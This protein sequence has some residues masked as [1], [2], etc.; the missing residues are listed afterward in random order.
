MIFPNAATG[1]M[2][3]QGDASKQLI[4]LEKMLAA[5]ETDYPTHESI[6]RPDA[7]KPKL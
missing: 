4:A 1:I 6:V 7:E 5:L 3:N 2:R